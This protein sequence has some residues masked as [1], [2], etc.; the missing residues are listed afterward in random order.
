M[1]VS[2]KELYPTEKLFA[3]EE[4]QIEHYV[5]AF[6]ENR[7]VEPIKVIDFD[8]HYYIISG[9]AKMLAA[10]RMSLDFIDV[11]VVIPEM[12]S[13]WSSKSN[14]ISVLKGV[15][16]STLYDY[17]G[18]GFFNYITYPKYYRTEG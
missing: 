15:G 10:N 11:D 18:V 1:K 13:F 3:L 5:I 12:N 8:G 6:K 2:P 17:E 4:K 7:N 14:I 16:I 9:H